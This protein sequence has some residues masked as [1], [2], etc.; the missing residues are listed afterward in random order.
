MSFDLPPYSTLPDSFWIELTKMRGKGEG[1]E[2]QDAVIKKK[3][4]YGF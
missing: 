3:K 1:E 2:T 4:N